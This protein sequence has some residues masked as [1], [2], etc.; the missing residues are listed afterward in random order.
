MKKWIGLLTAIL[1]LLS[2]SLTADEAPS[3]IIAAPEVL[4]VADD[5]APKQVGKASLDSTNAA[6]SSN[7][8]KY[9]LAAGAVAIGVAAII[10]IS[11]HHGHHRHSGS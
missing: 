1:C 5:Q 8:A 6:K 4:V 10:L 11:R 3:E 7:A 9:V 2:S